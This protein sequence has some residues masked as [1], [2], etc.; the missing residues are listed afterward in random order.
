MTGLDSRSVHE[1]AAPAPVTLPTMD[2]LDALT[3]E[4]DAIDRVLGE[5]DA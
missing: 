4:L 1:P 3:A 2:D 5:L